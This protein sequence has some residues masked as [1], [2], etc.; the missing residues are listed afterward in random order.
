MDF[1]TLTAAAGLVLLLNMASTD[2]RAKNPDSPDRTAWQKDLLD[3]RAKHTAELQKPDGWLSLAGLEWLEPGDNS[4][5]GPAD[6]KIHLASAKVARLGVLQLEGQA[7]R[8]VEPAGGF[9][10]DF[11]V[12]GAP[13]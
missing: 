4:F 10:P 9:P 8:L 7:V 11:L 1:R 2:S 13:A 6:N 12:A 3:W 5:A